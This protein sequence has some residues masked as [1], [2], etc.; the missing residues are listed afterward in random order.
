MQCNCTWPEPS[1]TILYIKGRYGLKINIR[2]I[3]KF[4]W[5]RFYFKM[6]FL[7]LLSPGFDAGVSWVKAMCVWSWKS[8]TIF[9]GRS[10][11]TIRCTD[12]SQTVWTVDGGWTN[13]TVQTV[14]T[15][16]VAGLA[17]NWLC[18]GGYWRT[19]K[20]K[21]HFRTWSHCHK[22]LFSNFL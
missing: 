14:W 3:N 11:G 20:H 19:P 4:S 1:T 18:T 2:I 5:L 16:C 12:T 22:L 10:Y 7:N 17:E 9:S 21:I 13:G 15:V 8:G 6:F